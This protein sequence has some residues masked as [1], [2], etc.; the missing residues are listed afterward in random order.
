M[1]WLMSLTRFAVGGLSRR[2]RGGGSTLDLHAHWDRA[3]RS[4]RTRELE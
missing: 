4:W 3:S 2:L 1:R